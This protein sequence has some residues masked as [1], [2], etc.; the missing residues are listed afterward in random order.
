[1]DHPR[2]G[3]TLI[4]LL[5]VIAIIA[6]MIGILLPAVQKVRESAARTTCANNLKQIALATHMYH[7]AKRKLPHGIAHPNPDG[8]HTSLFVDILPYLEQEALYQRWNFKNISANYGD[9]SSVAAQP[10]KVFICPTAGVDQNPTRYGSNS[11]GMCTYGANG[12]TKTFPAHR[13]TN[14]GL[15]GV[16]TALALAKTQ[17][18]LTDVSDG[19]SNTIMFG[20]HVIGD[21]N[22]DSWQTA[23]II[24]SPDPPLQ[25]LSGLCSWARVP[26]PNAAAA[27]LL[28]GSVSINFGY[29]YFYQPPVPAPGEPPPSPIP[30]NSMNINVWDRLSAYGSRHPGLCGFARADGSVQFMRESTP[31][32][33]LIA[34][35]TRRG[36]EAVAEQ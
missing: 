2:R 17:V 10:L 33:L 30:W 29:P 1:M 8:R 9:D 35:S 20:E 13:A 7:E 25:A 19:T 22:L 11:L 6:V 34:L 12:G 14:D 24:P 27:F 32:E 26:G 23:P 28:A 31:I 5:V 36:G 3:F 4:E 15:F 18:S 21:G 16:S